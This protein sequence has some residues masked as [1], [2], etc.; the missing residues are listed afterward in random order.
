MIPWGCSAGRP[1]ADGGAFLL[2]HVLLGCDG[3]VLQ[4]SSVRVSYS[5]PGAAALSI[6][7]TDSAGLIVVHNM[8]GGFFDKHKESLSKELSRGAALLGSL[9]A[10]RFGRDV[11]STT[12]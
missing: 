8:L 11:V 4:S 6:L 3:E 12:A 9:Q 1:A 2:V 7:L 5:F 10:D